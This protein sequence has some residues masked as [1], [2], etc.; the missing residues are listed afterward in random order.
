MIVYGNAL[1]KKKLIITLK[2]IVF[3]IV[4]NTNF[5]IKVQHFLEDSSHFNKYTK[6][7]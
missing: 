1:Y 3:E 5:L 7:L 2:I 4:L 6:L